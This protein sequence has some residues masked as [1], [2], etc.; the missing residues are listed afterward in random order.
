M[1]YAAARDYLLSFANYEQKDRFAYDTRTWNLRAFRA[2]LDE[3]GAPDRA[4]SV[5]H[6]AGT[7]GKGVVAAAV[8]ALLTAAGERVGLY[9][10]PHLVTLRERV[11]VNGAMIGAAQFAAHVERLKELQER[12]GHGVDGG[13][14]TTFELLTAL[15]LLHFVEAGCR[16]ALLEVGLGGRLD[17]T[18]VVERPTLCLFSRIAR[19]HENVL[20]RGLQ[21]VAVEKAGILKPGVPALSVAQEPVVEEVLRKRA[22]ELG[23][24]LG[25]VN[26]GRELTLSDDGR[27]AYRGRPTVLRGA[28]QRDNLALALA[29]FR[30]LAGRLELPVA[31]DVARRG[32]AAL[33]WPGRL[34]VVGREPAVILDGGHNP[35]ALEAA[36]EH[37]AAR[38]AGRRLGVFGASANK[39]LAALTRPLPQVF[40]HLYLCAAPTPRAADPAGLADLLP[41]ERTTVVGEGVARA[42]ELALAAAAP[43]DLVAVLG[44]LYVVG[45][46]KAH[47]AE[48]G[49]DGSLEVYRPGD[50]EAVPTE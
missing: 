17:A 22:A 7:N 35:A 44:S 31:E 42:L 46:A 30:G 11:R 32:L 41:R 47:A 9:T 26:P 48:L 18:N 25:F 5:I 23:C 14:R 13:Y 2:F 16:W 50:D 36:L 19:D 12:M 37:I 21:R 49:L 24:R 29:A 3:L 43:A 1:D 33:R 28:F 39:D 20:G 4:L 6:V 10:S 15:A 45:E 38:S 40:D 8:G 34:E 27:V